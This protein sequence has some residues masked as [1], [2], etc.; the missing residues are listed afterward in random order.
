MRKKKEVERFARWC[1]AQCGVP[2]CKI[3]Y[4]PA[5]SLIRN[6]KYGFGLYIWDEGTSDPGEIYVAYNIPKWG[7]MSVVAH[8]IFH[9]RQQLKIGLDNMDKESS[10]AEAE[11]ATDEL[12]GLWMIRGGKVKP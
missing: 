9:H 1:F 5:E 7:V 8:E 2:P 10:E 6:G 11:R 3:T 12:M 4:A